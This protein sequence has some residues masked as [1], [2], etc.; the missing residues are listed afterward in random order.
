MTSHEFF[1]KPE[2]GVGGGGCSNDFLLMSTTRFSTEIKVPIHQSITETA[3]PRLVHLMDI[4]VNYTLLSSLRTTHFNPS[5]SKN[6]YPGV[7][8]HHNK[9][10]EEFVFKL[11]SSPT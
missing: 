8:S 9:K 2:I 10:S 1:A 3:S 4:L 6:G 5:T 11:T 7:Q